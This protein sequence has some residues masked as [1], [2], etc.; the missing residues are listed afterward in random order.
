[1]AYRIYRSDDPGAIAA[2]LPILPRVVGNANIGTNGIAAVATI[3]DA[4]LVNGY[5]GKP[6]AGWTKPFGSDG[7]KHLYLSGSATGAAIRLDSGLNSV[8]ACDVSVMSNPT[9]LGHSTIIGT[10]VIRCGLRSGGAWVIF[11]DEKSFMIY[12]RGDPTLSLTGGAWN[13]HYFGEMVNFESQPLPLSIGYIGSVSGTSYSD[14]PGQWASI[15]KSA[16]VAPSAYPTPRINHSSASIDTIRI[17]GGPFFIGNGP[18]QYQV[19]LSSTSGKVLASDV[20]LTANNTLLSKFR[21]LKT[22]ES[23][24]WGASNPL[25]ILTLDG[26]KYAII[27]VYSNMSTTMTSSSATEAM[28]LV[29]VE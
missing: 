18:A 15:Y 7:T 5:A 3:L 25:D 1:M 16:T 11:A 10:N 22:L 24:F 21:G 6:A 23:A 28:F 2:G 4:V 8:S 20:F 9:T 27:Y 14:Y 29:E 26:K 12:S 17:M 13:L 19:P